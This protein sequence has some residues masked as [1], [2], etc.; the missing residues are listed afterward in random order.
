MMKS[1]FALALAILLAGCGNGVSDEPAY[2]FAAAK[3]HIYPEGY[4]LVRQFNQSVLDASHEARFG[5]KVK[6]RYFDKIA[7]EKLR[8]VSEQELSSAFVSKFLDDHPA[9]GTT[10][11]PLLDGK[12][13]TITGISGSYYTL[14]VSDIE[15]PCELDYSKM[16]YQCPELKQPVY[17]LYKRVKGSEVLK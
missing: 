8:H 12:V 3:Q 11:V 5:D 6:G 15:Q 14:R 1:N 2:V 9:V 4:D 16:P 7:P 17:V 10:L 13:A